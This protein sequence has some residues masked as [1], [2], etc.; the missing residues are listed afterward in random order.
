MPKLF[1]FIVI[2]V[3]V[4]SCNLSNENDLL[5]EE[6]SFKRENFKTNSILKGEVID[7]DAG[8]APRVFNVI[9]DT[10]VV[11]ENYYPSPYYYNIYNL[12]SEQHIM[13]LAKKGRG[14]YEFLSCKFMY[15][16]NEQDFFSIHDISS[17]TVTKY[18]IDSLITFKENYIA[19]R[20]KLPGVVKDYVFLTSDSIIAYN[21]YYFNSGNIQNEARP[22]LA[23]DLKNPLSDDVYI[24]Q[25]KYF[26]FN[27][28]GAYVLY[29]E[30]NDF[31][32]LVHHY[33]DKIEI[34]NKNLDLINRL[35]GP[36]NIKPKYQIGNRNDIKTEKGK[37]S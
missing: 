21:H 15:R 6:P 14:P 16:S 2:V 8:L 7:F 26:A 12:N 19:K 1:S 23:I 3:L 24:N 20:F 37:I 36:D 27:A 28:S 9:Q 33:E 5:K 32:W 10:L 13:G 17:Q 31:I 25:S 35:V 11:V 18:D 34:F 30:K 29:S 22:L 4:V